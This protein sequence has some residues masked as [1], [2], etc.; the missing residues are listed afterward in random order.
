MCITETPE[1]I[2]TQ[3]CSAPTCLCKMRTVA[4]Q[5]GAAAEGATTTA[6]TAATLRPT[7]TPPQPHTHRH[8]HRHRHT[9][10]KETNRRETPSNRADSAEISDR[11]AAERRSV[12]TEAET[13]QRIS[14]RRHRGKRSGKREKKRE[15]ERRTKKRVPPEYI[16]LTLL[17]HLSA[18]YGPF[19]TSD[20]SEISHRG[21]HGLYGE[22][23]EVSAQTEEN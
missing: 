14:L 21:T 18:S 19:F 22:T 12:D 20:Q 9:H 3:R 23:C 10:A 16:S 17:L 4:A 6:T 15:R 7:R 8:T 11:A 1:N 13:W 5:T 2:K